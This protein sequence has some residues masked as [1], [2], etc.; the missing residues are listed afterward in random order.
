MLVCFATVLLARGQFPMGNR[1][2]QRALPIDTPLQLPIKLL[3]GVIP[4]EVFAAKGGWD[5]GFRPIVW[6]YDLKQPFN[7]TAHAF[8]RELPFVDG[9][10]GVPQDPNKETNNIQLERTVSGIQQRV[11]IR[12]SGRFPDG[13][14]DDSKQPAVRVI[15]TESVSLDGPEP[16]HWLDRHVPFPVKNFP[17]PWSGLKGAPMSV[18]WSESQGVNE[19]Q[20]WF[21][22]LVHEPYQVVLDAVNTKLAPL[23]YRTPKSLA[24]AD[25][26][27]RTGG[28]F[29]W[30]DIHPGNSKKA[31]QGEWTTVTYTTGRL[32]RPGQTPGPWG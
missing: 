3:A 27:K 18:R 10:P 32:E 25:F 11:E 13:R 8:G 16:R 24:F 29:Y 5:R 17:I 23:G 26:R 15:I 28:T 7:K 12:Q 19:I 30:V 1:P 9:Q 21:S 4:A 22:F 31:N 2:Q 14:I 6:I 20:Y